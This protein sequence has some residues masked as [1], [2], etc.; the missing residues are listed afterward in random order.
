M[1]KY[2]KTTG[3]KIIGIIPAR[4]AA[5]RFPGKPLKKICNIEMLSHV[6]LRA[7]QFN[8]WSNLTVALCD[9]EIKNFCIEKDYP[10]TITSI[11]HVRC[12]DRVYE[13]SKKIKNIK[14]NDII[15]CVQG[16]EPMLKPDMISKVIKPLIKEK[17][18]CSVLAMDIENKEQYLNQDIVKIVHDLKG[19][20]LYTSRSPIPHTKKFS[21]KIGAKRIYGI[22]A[23]TY[24][25]LKTFALTKPSHLENVEACDSNRICDHYSNQ[26]IAKYKFFPSYSVDTPEDLK[27]V[28]KSIK[29]DNLFKKYS[30][31]KH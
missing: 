17:K 19:R 24:K 29:K 6:Y 8:N 26:Y 27:K 16:D 9:K 7:K 12:L 15:V 23:F 18:E 11:K 2:Q 28:E 25:F 22:F 30:K 3:R 31:N 20:V 1:K 5:S 4:M 14:P 10:Y 21:K 13:A